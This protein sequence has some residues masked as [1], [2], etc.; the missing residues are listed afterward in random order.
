MR[1]FKPV[2]AYILLLKGNFCKKIR[3]II[4]IISPRNKYE[5]FKLMIKLYILYLK[6][7]NK[8]MKT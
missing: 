7:A 1:K 2:D 4:K 3:K 5:N 6:K 8:D